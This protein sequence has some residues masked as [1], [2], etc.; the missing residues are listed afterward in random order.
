MT[1]DDL[2]KLGFTRHAETGGL[3]APRDVVTLVPYGRYYQLRLR[4]GDGSIS[5]VLAKAA[6]KL[7]EWREALEFRGLHRIIRQTL[8]SAA[9]RV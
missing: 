1:D 2:L 6:L 4:V 3:I 9:R 8:A 5:A 7:D